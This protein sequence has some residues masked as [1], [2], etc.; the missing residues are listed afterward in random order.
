MPTLK[1]QVSRA[2]PIYPTDNA[3]IPYPGN[4][5]VSDSNTSVTANK[6]V[7]STGDFVN[8]GVRIGDIVWNSAAN[9]YATVTNVDSATQLSLNADI[10]T[11]SPVTF[12]LFDAPQDSAG[13]V[14]YIGT[15]GNLV[16]LTSGDDI[17]TFTAI[18][19]GTFLPVNV[20]QVYAATTASNIIA[21]W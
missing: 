17:V 10:F 6:L 13:C 20:K 21:L 7:C 11:A 1:L 3:Q 5:L 16:V 2:L 8:R 9:T 18:P 14:L 19:A 12:Q 4:L 15:T